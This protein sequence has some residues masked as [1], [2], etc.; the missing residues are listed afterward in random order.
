MIYSSTQLLE[1]AIC[2]TGLL[3]RKVYNIHAKALGLNVLDR[4]ALIHVQFRPRLTQ[5]ELA[6]HLEIEAQNLIRVLDRLIKKGYIEKTS[7]PKD[8][9]A[10]CIQITQKGENILALLN[11]KV[12]QN[13]RTMLENIPESAQKNLLGSLEMMKGN[14]TQILNQLEADKA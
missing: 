8:R 14:L 2:D 7:H 1:F 11:Q 6:G 3:I 13:Y 5:I 4:R 12:S 9:R 10:K